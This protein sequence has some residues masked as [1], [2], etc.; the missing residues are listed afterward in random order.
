MG[1]GVLIR[2]D[3]VERNMLSIER[4]KSCEKNTEIDEKG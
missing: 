1:N 4:I 2:G 3:N